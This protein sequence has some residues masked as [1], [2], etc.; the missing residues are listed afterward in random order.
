M[1][2]TW[3]HG[4]VRKTLAWQ[5]EREQ[6]HVKDCAGLLWAPVAF[7]IRENWQLDTAVERLHQWENLRLALMGGSKISHGGIP[8]VTKLMISVSLMILCPMLGTRLMCLFNYSLTIKSWKSDIRVGI[9]SIR[10]VVKK[11]PVTSFPCTPLVKKPNLSL[12]T[13]LILSESH[14]MSY[15]T[16]LLLIWLASGSYNLW[17]QINI[18]SSLKS[19]R[20]WLKYSTTVVHNNFHF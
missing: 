11:W 1:L 15:N 8:E 7:G 10:E 17:F 13:L 20:V 12:W 14:Y 6:G 3:A 9:W 18:I 2:K 19:V 5:E 4:D 16:Y